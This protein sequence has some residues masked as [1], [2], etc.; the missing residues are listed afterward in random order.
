MFVE[1]VT[2]PASVRRLRRRSHGPASTGSGVVGWH[3]ERARTHN[4]DGDGDRVRV[5]AGAGA[6]G[7]WGLTCRGTA[8]VS[9]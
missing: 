9:L 5:K 1:V 7:E 3:R 8:R 4:H 2:A 6:G